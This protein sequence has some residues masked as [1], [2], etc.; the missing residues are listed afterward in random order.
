MTRT[1]SLKQPFSPH[2]KSGVD[3]DTESRQLDLRDKNTVANLALILVTTIFCL[4]MITVGYMLK[5]Y[6]FND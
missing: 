4:V 2:F 5:K 1:S 6:V 3:M